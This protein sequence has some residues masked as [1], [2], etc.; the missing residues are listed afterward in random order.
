MLNILQNFKNLWPTCALLALAWMALGCSPTTATTDTSS[1]PPDPN[2]LIVI[3]ITSPTKDVDGNGPF[4]TKSAKIT[5]TFKQPKANAK[6]LILQANGQYIAQ[7]PITGGDFSF[8]F[9]TD[10]VDLKKKDLFKCN[11]PASIIVAAADGPQPLDDKGVAIAPSPALLSSTGISVEMDHCLPAISIESPAQDGLYVGHVR[12]HA[13]IAEK[14]LKEATLLING[15]AQEK[16]VPKGGTVNIE[17]EFKFQEDVSGPITVTL[18]A[19]DLAGNSSEVTISATIVRQPHFMGDDNRYDHSILAMNDM[20]LGRFNNDN[21]IDAVVGGPKGVVLRYGV[22]EMDN[23]KPPVA[24]GEDDDHRKHSLRFAN[25]A[26]D[27]KAT[28]YLLIPGATV[29]FVFTHRFSSETQDTGGAPVDVVIAIGKKTDGKTAAW[30]LWNFPLHGLKLVDERELPDEVLSAAMGDLNQDGVPDLIAGAKEDSKG[31]T[32]LLLQTNPECL[33]DKNI[34][35]PCIGQTDPKSVKSAQIFKDKAKTIL[36]KGVDGISSIAVANFYPDSPGQP[37]LLDVCVGTPSR[38]YIS[39]Y[40]NLTHD[41]ILEQAQ[42]SFYVVGAPDAAKIVAIDWSQDGTPDLIFSSTK[43]EIRW[44]KNQKNGTFAFDPGG[45]PLKNPYRNLFGFP[46]VDM[47]IAYIGPQS[48]AFNGGKDKTPYLILSGQGREVTA[49]PALLNDKS[50]EAHCFRAWIMGGNVVHTALANIDNDPA[51]NVDIVSLDLETTGLPVSL[52]LGLGD[53]SAPNAYHVCAPFV[54]DTGFGVQPLANMALQDFTKDGRP[55]LLLIAELSHSTIEPCPGAEGTFTGRPAWAWHMFMNVD[56][57]FNPAPRCAEFSPYSK[58]QSNASGVLGECDS[59]KPFGSIRALVAADLN[60]DKLIDL[61]SARDGAAY[62]LGASKAVGLESCKTLACVFDETHE[63]DNY[64]GDDYPAKDG[65]VINCCKNFAKS[66]KDKSK[67]LNG[68]GN[69]APMDRASVHVWLNGD[70]TKPFGITAAGTPLQPVQIAPFQAIAGGRNPRDLTTGDF[71]GDKKP[72]IVTVM[73]AEGSTDDPGSRLAARMR[74]FQN[75][76]NGK[77]VA[78]PQTGDKYQLTVKGGGPGTQVAVTYR[79]LA[80]DPVAVA[81]GAF[82]SMKLPSVF[83]LSKPDDNVTVVQGLG[84][85]KFTPQS[86]VFTLCQAANAFGLRDI[87]G[88]GLTDVLA[89]CKADVGFLAAQVTGDA[90]PPV[91]GTNANFKTKQ[92]LTEKPNDYIYLDTGDF[93]KDGWSDVVLVDSVRSV[94][95][96]YLGNGA[97]PG[98]ERYVLYEGNLLV[99]K[100]AVRAAKH[101]VH[102]DG[103]EDIVVMSEKSVTYL[104]NLMC[105]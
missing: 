4:F 57:K 103:C 62:S 6:Y 41:G 71:N 102:D 60:N 33:S 75:D 64:Y 81:T 31:L 54:T 12:I 19:L 73:K 66:D 88:D 16:I 99:A 61:V 51:G 34:A 10:G 8:E 30:A 52:G 59:L 76:G 13:T 89:A 63:V 2:D 82:G 23:A 100:G 80:Q 22:P 55:E 11:A 25:P 24:L 91:L 26:G 84:A 17:R 56:K 101:K 50:H 40:R 95:Q 46:A 48:P 14:E 7:Q 47:R 68:Y 83:A 45:D 28:E 104:K 69:G 86:W 97:A 36:H 98:K 77:L 37:P 20:A 38:P 1:G 15:E 49:I 18:N 65:T 67:S 21:L 87:N 44:I 9:E 39:C 58:S 43:G 85:G 90:W 105:P 79:T 3:T 78:V 96:I 29:N 94:V 42:D 35:V 5:G 72:D 93:N 74:L 32:T 53:F 70:P 92:V 27:A